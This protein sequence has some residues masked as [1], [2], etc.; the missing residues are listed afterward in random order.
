[1]NSSIFHQ[2]SLPVIPPPPPTL[3]RSNLSDL[4][5]PEKF[6][7]TSK[8][9]FRSFRKEETIILKDFVS[10]FNLISEKDES[11][12]QEPERNG[13]LSKYLSPEQF[14]F[15][16]ADSASETFPED[17]IL[18]TETSSIRGDFS[19]VI[20]LP[21]FVS[22]SKIVFVIQK[23]SKSTD[24]FN[25]VYGDSFDFCFVEAKNIVT[26]IVKFV[27]STVTVDPEYVLSIPFETIVS[28][29]LEFYDFIDRE[30]F[31]EFV[32]NWKFFFENFPNRQKDLKEMRFSTLFPLETGMFPMKERTDFLSISV[33]P[34]KFSEVD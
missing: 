22:D 21:Q 32:E 24:F 8:R 29:I 15:F 30:K 3:S 34:A 26:D 1:M 13:R 16:D 31:I 4:P 33:F 10:T 17:Q 14:I 25:I 5:P 18:S 12:I 11:H 23:H 6:S 20:N 28:E 2:M 9:G 27:L 19:V 7:F